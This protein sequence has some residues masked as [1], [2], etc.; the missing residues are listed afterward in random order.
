MPR[1]QAT[2]P[3][4]ISPNSVLRVRLPDGKGESFVTYIRFLHH[5]TLCMYL[6]L[7]LTYLHEFDVAKAE[8]KLRVPEGLSAGEE[9][10]FE[11]SSLGEIKTSATTKKPAETNN[12]SGKLKSHRGNPKKKK[13]HSD[14]VSTTQHANDRTPLFISVCLD[15]Y[16]K[17]YQALTQEPDDEFSISSSHYTAASNRSGHS[18]HQGRSSSK[19]RTNISIHLGAFDGDI[20][21]MRDFFT[22]LAVGMFIGLNVVLG[23]VAGV[24]WV[25]PE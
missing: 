19:E 21:N 4:G 15:F 22:A 11:V 23:F 13:H 18:T 10:Q 17:L 9:F 2:V 3:A 5:D 1:L 7:T 12:S 14:K 20:T 24:L 6:Q 16:Q 8:V 25:T